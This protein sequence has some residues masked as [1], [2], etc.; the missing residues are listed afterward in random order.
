MFSTST[1]TTSSTTPLY[2][3]CVADILANETFL[4]DAG[5]ETALVYGDKIALPCFASFT[6]LKTEAGAKRVESFYRDFCVVAK[7]HGRNMYLDTVTW[8]A[9]KDWGDKLGYSAKDLDDVARA[10]VDMIV[11]LRDEYASD[12]TKM[13]TS[14]AMGPRGDGYVVGATMTQEEA[15]EYH[16]QQVRTLA[17]TALDLI[18]VYTMTYAE[19]A[20]GLALAAAEVN[21][22]I[23]ISFT[24][25]TDGKLPSGATLREAIEAVDAACDSLGPG[26]RPIG[27]GIN[28]AHP[29][30]FATTLEAAAEAG[31]PWLHRLHALRANASKKSHAE[32]EKCTTLDCGD[33]VDL[34]TRYKALLPKLPGHFSVLGGCCGTNAQLAKAIAEVCLACEP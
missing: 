16:M 26:K 18:T 2:R 24:V 19:E 31:E 13:I 34:A 1:T 22:P 32:L 7:A 17:S 3:S 25:E 27:Y 5:L 23:V 33:D 20:A 10:S 12:D 21:M 4:C 28:C 15:K 8:R 29:V 14:G 6:M 30:H 9:S 11:R